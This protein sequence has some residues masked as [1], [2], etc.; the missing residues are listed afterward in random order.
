VSIQNALRFS[1]PWR[2]W[3]AIRSFSLSLN[4]YVHTESALKKLV[5]ILSVH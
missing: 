3:N 2:V 1:L 4:V 5:Y